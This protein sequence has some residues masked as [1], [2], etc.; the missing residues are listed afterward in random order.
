M[1]LLFEHLFADIQAALLQDCRECGG[2]STKVKTFTI[3]VPCD[4]Y[5]SLRIGS[6]IDLLLFPTVRSFHLIQQFQKT[7]Q[8]KKKHF[9]YLQL[10]TRYLCLGRGPGSCR[11]QPSP[12]PRP[13]MCTCSQRWCEPPGVSC[14][15]GRWG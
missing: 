9:S 13:P 1:F 14:P 12:G 15:L 3:L 5:L 8:F 11:R 7:N 2:A 10:L 4:A 6:A